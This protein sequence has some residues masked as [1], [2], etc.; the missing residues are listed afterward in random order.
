LLNVQRVK[1]NLFFDY[2]QGKSTS[3]YYNFSDNY[4]LTG[5]R[6]SDYTSLGG[7]LTLDVNFFRLLPQ[8]EIGARATYRQENVFNSGGVIFE[9]L[10]GNIPL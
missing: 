7:E 5:S 4:Y 6:T 8:F 1:L 9:F 3:Y 2:G 10:L